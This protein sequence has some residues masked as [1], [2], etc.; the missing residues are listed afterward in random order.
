M[1]PLSFTAR[2]L[3]EQDILFVERVF[4]G[5]SYAVPFP[6]SVMTGNEDLLLSMHEV[7]QPSVCLQVLRSIGYKT[8]PVDRDVPFDPKKGIIPNLSGKVLQSELAI[9]FVSL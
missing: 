8:L 7:K 4:R 9:D 2:P 5:F 6:F 1:A 3:I